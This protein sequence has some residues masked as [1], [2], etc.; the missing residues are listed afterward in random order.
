MKSNIKRR[1]FLK[2]FLTAPALAT[3]GILLNTQSAKS[4]NKVER[5]GGSK[6]KISL[7]AFSFNE[8]LRNK[9]MTLDDLLDFCAV[10]NFDAVDITGY[11]FPGYP[12]VPPDDYIY[13]LKRKA[14]LLGLDIS[15]TGV[16]NDF[17]NADE[18]KRKE[19]IALVKKWIEVA[20]KL[21]A[22]VIRIFSGTQL[23]AGYS[24]EQVMAWMVKDIKEC[25]AYGKQHGIIVAVQNHND[26]IKT[27]DQAQKIIEAVN[28]DW[29][30]LVL[31]IGSYRS[32]DPYKQIG[33]TAKYAVNWQLK[34]NMYVNETEVK[35]DL[36]KVIGIIKASGYRGYVPIETLSAGDPKIK[37]PLFL[38]EV[39]KAM[40]VK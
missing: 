11:Y 22:P 16:R 14:F 31:D 38:A 1:D 12:N 27:A 36:N 35:T 15:G 18:S 20:E 2:T 28:S 33:Q 3:T 21:G 40:E 4:Q 17:T 32:G 6:L 26:F 10:N 7:N 19:D 30:G 37:V 8:P 39:R 13:A 5:P 24:W 29:F 23:P 9:S 34:E 25:V